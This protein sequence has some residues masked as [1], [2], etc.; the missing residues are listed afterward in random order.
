MDIDLLADDDERKMLIAELHRAHQHIMRCERTSD[1][2]RD[3]EA[4]TPL[5][6]ACDAIDDALRFL[7]RL[8]AA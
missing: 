3:G 6:K 5:A 7:R 1:R 8:K 4:I 2:T